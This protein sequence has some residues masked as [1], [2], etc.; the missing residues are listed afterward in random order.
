MMLEVAGRFRTFDQLICM[1]KNTSPHP[2]YFD[3]PEVI[4]LGA[5]SSVATDVH[6]SSDMQL[7]LDACDGTSAAEDSSTRDTNVTQPE[8]TNVSAKKIGLFSVS[9]HKIQ[10]YKDFGVGLDV[11]S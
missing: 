3:P 1:S 5:T 9:G 2:E 10:V 4:D 7:V 8:M 6:L 11:H